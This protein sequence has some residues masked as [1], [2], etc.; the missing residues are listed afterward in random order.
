LI[1]NIAFA[2]NLTETQDEPSGT[3][4]VLCLNDFIDFA[5]GIRE[6]EADFHAFLDGDNTKALGLFDDAVKIYKSTKFA[7]NDCFSV[8]LDRIIQEWDVILN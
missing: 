8:N 3:V 1:W 5:A 7:L 4:S 6:I 2:A